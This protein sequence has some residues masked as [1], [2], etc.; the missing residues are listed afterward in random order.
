[1]GARF[2][3]AEVDRLR[4]LVPDPSTG[5]LT[6]TT[7]VPSKP[8]NLLT[9]M[10]LAAWGNV[11][12]VADRG[13]NCVWRWVGQELQLWQPGLVRPFGLALDATA[14]TAYVLDT[15]GVWAFDPLN[16][17]SAITLV[18]GGGST[19]TLPTPVS[20]TH[21]TLPTIYSV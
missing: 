6:A 10:A 17:G 16:L 14:T 2:V 12:W 7:F 4:T 11:V 20:Y 3:L 9:P 5:Y 8:V 13:A 15:R 21:L 19:A 1:M 18:C